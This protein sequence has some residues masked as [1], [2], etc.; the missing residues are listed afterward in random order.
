MGRQFANDSMT[1]S[2]IN[3][4]RDEYKNEIC[5]DTSDEKHDGTT[6]GMGSFNWDGGQYA[7]GLE[8]GG[9]KYGTDVTAPKATSVTVIG[10]RAERG[11]EN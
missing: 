10:D 1:P 5:N 3:I 4:T 11:P 2:P 6:P 8:G 7:H 9:L